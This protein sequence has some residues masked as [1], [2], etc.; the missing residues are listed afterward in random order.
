[1]TARD[2][3]RPF[4]TPS[5]KGMRD[6]VISE[7]TA[8]VDVKSRDAKELAALA[9]ERFAAVLRTAPVE[10]T[11]KTGLRDSRRARFSG[12]ERLLWTTTFES[13]WHRCIGKPIN[14]SAIH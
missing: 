7:P 10:E 2:K 6:E 14:R 8:I 9:S 13:E 5:R 11:M 12:G 1:M 3:T 4:T